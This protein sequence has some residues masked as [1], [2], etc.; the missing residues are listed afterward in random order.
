[1]DRHRTTLVNRLTVM[2]NSTREKKTT[3]NRGLAKQMVDT[4]MAEVFS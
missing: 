2:L 4:M 1:M 3:T